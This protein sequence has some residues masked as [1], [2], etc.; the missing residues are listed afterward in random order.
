MKAQNVIFRLALIAG[1]SI[2]SAAW[3]VNM[4]LGQILPYL[5]CRHQ[6]RFSA[7]AS[8]AA[9][10]LACVAA[11][12]SWRATARARS[13]QPLTATSVF[14]GSM[15]A[16]SAL[17]FAFALSMQGIASLVLSGCER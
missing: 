2:S 10:L 13:T 16:L 9:T 6:A 8:F 11:V 12:A 5:D 14:L 15:S 7:L 17:I 4:Q 3:A 1:L